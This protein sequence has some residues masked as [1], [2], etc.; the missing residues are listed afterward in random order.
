MSYASQALR[1][2]G[3]TQA[4][5]VC[6]PSVARLASVMTHAA[7]LLLSW[8]VLH[9]TGIPPELFNAALT[10]THV[11]AHDSYVLAGLSAT[12]VARMNETLTGVLRWMVLDRRARAILRATPAGDG[13]GFLARGLASASQR[14]MS[15]YITAAALATYSV[16]PHLRP[17]SWTLCVVL[18]AALTLARY[19]ALVAA[20]ILRL[21]PSVLRS[22][23][24]AAAAA[25]TAALASSP[26]RSA[27]S[28]KRSGSRPKRGARSPSRSPA[29]ARA[30]V[31]AVAPL[32]ITFQLVPK[33]DTARA[34][35]PTDAEVRLLAAALARGGVALGPAFAMDAATKSVTA[36]FIAVAPPTSDV[37]ALLNA[38]QLP[39]LLRR[40]GAAYE[41]E[42]F[43]ARSGC[44]ATRVAA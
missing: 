26:T 5:D 6:D 37:R 25:A 7:T 8:S 44:P 18:T 1:A 14:V 34:I 10:A 17:I 9:D 28:P 13:G 30:D 2:V 35:A 23:T 4:P 16:S 15:S 22:L 31:P 36:A 12:A 20:P 42:L 39:S 21:L 38:V 27:R 32:C 19:S 33:A 43:L 29:P 24:G 3:I 41:W 40:G 11:A